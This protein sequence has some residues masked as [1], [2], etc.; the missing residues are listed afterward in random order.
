MKT[1]TARP[2]HVNMCYNAPS[3]QASQGDGCSGA[4]PGTAVRMK[5]T[6]SPAD[7]RALHWPH[8]GIGSRLYTRATLDRCSGAAAPSREAPAGAAM[9]LA[10][11]RVQVC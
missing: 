10:A 9:R 7:A 8:T 11:C 3:G 1:C 4:Q 6:A 2:G 5:F